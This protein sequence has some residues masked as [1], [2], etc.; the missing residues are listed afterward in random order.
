[1][2]KVFFIAFILFC[3]SGIGQTT[4]EINEIVNN[5]GRFN[6]EFITIEGLVTQYTPGSAKSTAYYMLKGDFGGQIKVN[7]NSQKPE[8]NS[9]YRVSG[10][11]VIDQLNREAY[12]IEQQRNKISTNDAG[13]IQ[14]VESGKDNT[15]LILIVG[16]VIPP[17]DYKYLYDS[18]VVAIF[19]PGTRIT[20]AGIKILELLIKA[21]GNS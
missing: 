10:T 2:R 18:G 8:T 13:N 12:L 5:P 16:G 7:T 14:I 1:M 20:S 15:T 4:T 17:Q 21:Y 19:G 3:Q 11:V 6:N 9:K